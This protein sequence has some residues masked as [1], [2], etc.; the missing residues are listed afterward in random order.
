MMADNNWPAVGAGRARAV[1]L[2]DV[3]GVINVTRPGWGSAPRRGYACTGGQEFRIRWAPALVDRIRALHQG[4]LVHIRWCSSWCGDARQLENLLGLPRLEY[5]WT[6]ERTGPA[7]TL[8]KL[9]AARDVL[10][11][12]HRLVWTDDG[13]VPTSGPVFEELTAGGQVLLIAPV[14]SRCLQPE[15]LEQIEQ[16]LRG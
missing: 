9:A 7:A 3:D 16:F 1:W 13:A 6:E 2:L 12:G 5:A 14:P 15:H 11:R 4:G 8:A 10:A